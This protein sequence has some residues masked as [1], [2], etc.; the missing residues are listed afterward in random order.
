[1]SLDGTDGP[2]VAER[3]ARSPLVAALLSAIIPGAGQLYAGRQRRGIILLAL[4]AALIV[5][6]LVWVAAD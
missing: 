3:V 6:A 5:A 1:M 4:S 2:E